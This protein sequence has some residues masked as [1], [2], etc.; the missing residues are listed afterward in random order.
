MRAFLSRIITGSKRLFLF[1]RVKETGLKTHRYNGGA[2]AIQTRDTVPYWGFSWGFLAAA[3]R[4][5]G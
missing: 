1:P 2:E 5:S 4:R 3:K